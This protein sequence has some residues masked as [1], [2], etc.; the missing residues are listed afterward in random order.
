MSA[1]PAQLAVGLVSHT[2]AGKTT[3]ARTLLRRDIGEV[4]DR[5]H[6]TEV[7]ERH[8]LIESPQRDVLSLWDTPG[9]GDSVR[10]YKRLLQSEQPVGWV[11]SQVW[12]RFLDRPFYSGQQALRSA[13]EACDV[14][15]YVINA[16]EL[17]EEARYVDVELKILAWVGKPVILVLNQLGPARSQARTESELALWRAHLAGH[18]CIRGALSL[19]AFGR[20]WV[21]EDH[22][23]AQ[24]EAVLPA[25]L[26][27]AGARLRAAWRA[28][29]L[30][31]F[32]RSMG[33]LARQLTNL[34][35]DEESLQ[36]TDVAAKLRGWVGNVATGRDRGSVELARAH[37]VMAQRLVEAARSAMDELITLHGLAG[38]TAAD[39]LQQLA[40]ELTVER[41]ADEHKAGLWGG[42]ISGAAGGI[43]ADLATGGLSFGAGAL[44]GGVLGAM[45]ALGA[46]SAYNMARGRENGRVR[47]SSDLL[48]ARVAT[49]LLGY[50]AVAHFGRGRGEFVQGAVPDHWQAALAVIAR[51]KPRLEEAWTIAHEQSNAAETERQLRRTL[52]ELTRE[53]LLT[54][55]PDCAAALSGESNAELAERVPRPPL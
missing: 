36:G 18:S 32:E 44:I 25:E 40:R 20:A 24:L 1:A 5:A 54:L 7:A 39:Q 37:D 16:S 53:V 55:Y 31:V 51:Y 52:T 48:N 11:L 47:W 13:R 21:Q 3:L 27:P 15:L 42:L 34:A 49:A 17:P 41:P 12:D 2:N 8:V 10:L 43:A 38:R 33:V 45:G 28:R 6:V 26:Q 9:F 29:N 22:L 23:F 46:V 14:I 30:D 35:L 4:G 19:D 50:L